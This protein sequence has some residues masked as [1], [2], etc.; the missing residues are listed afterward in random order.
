MLDL[1]GNIEVINQIMKCITI[2]QNGVIIIIYIKIYRLEC[3][4]LLMFYAGAKEMLSC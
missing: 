1:K 4:E 3:K 2:L